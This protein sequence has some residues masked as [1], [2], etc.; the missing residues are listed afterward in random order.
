MCIFFI[1]KQVKRYQKL[2]IFSRVKIGFDISSSGWIHNEQFSKVKGELKRDVT[3]GRGGGRATPPPPPALPKACRRL[4]RGPQDP[5]TED[6]KTLTTEAPSVRR[7]SELGSLRDS[8]RTRRR[9][10]GGKEG[11]V[12]IASGS[13][14]Q[15]HPRPV[16]PPTLSKQQHQDH[17]DGGGNSRFVLNYLASTQIHAL[18]M[19]V[20]AALRVPRSPHQ[21]RS[22]ELS[23]RNR[24][25]QTG[26]FELTCSGNVLAL[27]TGG[28]VCA[29]REL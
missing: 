12:R 24:K 6:Y 19:S 22:P 4:D 2:Y 27:R 23:E 1:D 21:L 29:R 10:G 28:A 17:Q 25:L 15:K 5:H 20:N 18:S 14:R 8:T 26:V 9:R 11:S 13:R 7:L 16:T 3:T